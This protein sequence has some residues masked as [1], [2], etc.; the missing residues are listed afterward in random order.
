VFWVFH[1]RQP[2]RCAVSLSGNFLKSAN[3]V[4][5]DSLITIELPDWPIVKL[6]FDAQFFLLQAQ[7]SLGS[8]G[9][10]F[11]CQCFGG[12]VHGRETFFFR[13]ITGL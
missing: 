10:F 12:R 1:K 11:R 2:T 13:K 8:D 6:D 7:P 5:F 9:G 4:L 3:A